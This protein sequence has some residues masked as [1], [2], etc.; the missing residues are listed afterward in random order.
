MGRIK[1][2]IYKFKSKSDLL[3]SEHGREVTKKYIELAKMLDVEYEAK[4]FEKWQ[5]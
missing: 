1:T 2:P 5:S 4:I 3:T